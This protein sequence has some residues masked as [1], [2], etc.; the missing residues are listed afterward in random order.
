MNGF[1]VIGD[2]H[3]CADA[4]WALLKG[5]GYHETS[6]GWSHASR[7]AVFVG[8]LIDRGPQ[9]RE[10]VSTVRAMVDS[11]AARIV[12]GNHE[13]N[14]VAWATPDPALPGEF[15][16]P[17]RGPKGAKNLH[18]H[19][20]FLDGVR[21]GS[22]L[23]HELVDW[24]KSIPLWLDLGGLRVV[25]AC[26]STAHME[27]LRPVLDD[28][29]SLTADCLVEAC[30]RGTVSYDAI[31]TILKG[32]EIALG[33]GQ[34]YLDKDGHR[35]KD[36]RARW[37]DGSATTLNA[38]A[39]I[40]PGSTTPD[41]E[42]FPELPHTPVPSTVIPR[43]TGDV[44]VVFG[45]YWRSGAPHVINDRAVCVDFSAIKGGPMVAYRWSGEAHLTNDSLFAVYPR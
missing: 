45:H 3:G 7:Q 42:P 16:R 28:A 32:P 19:A 2:V 8:D 20:A 11:G 27:S 35:R 40:P 5:M 12:L 9:Q 31:E 44:P 21:E 36:A 41:G 34:S 14:A 4:L 26:W 29:A 37:W 39:E 33:D 23:H 6:R 24:F 10:V 30:Q 1:D 38:L 25:H 22:A 43:Y 15:L 18:Q 13:F 17:H